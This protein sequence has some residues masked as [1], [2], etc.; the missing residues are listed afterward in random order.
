MI[1][2]FCTYTVYIRA[3]YF[4]MFAHAL[5]HYVLFYTH[6]YFV[7]DRSTCLYHRVE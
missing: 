1:I 4:N 7:C 2:M 3:Y 6:T 5:M